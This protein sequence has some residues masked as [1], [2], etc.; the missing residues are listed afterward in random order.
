M[1]TSFQQVTIVGLGLIGGSLGLALRR[2]RLAREVIG[3]SRSQAMVRRAKARRAITWG[4]TDPKRAVQDA[5]L[6]VLAT[7]VDTIVPQGKRL[8][9]WMRPGSVLTDVGSV[10]TDIVAALERSLPRGVAFVGAHPIAGSEQRGLEAAEARL[11]EGAV[12][13]L[14]TTA[15]TNARALRRVK[16]LWASLGSEVKTMSPAQ[17]DRLL[18]GTSHLSHLAAYCLSLSLE[19]GAPRCL[20]QSFLAATRVAKS[21]P[22]LWD[23]ILVSNQ[24]PLRAAMARF[25]RHWRRLHRLLSKADRAALRR[26][27]AQAKARRDALERS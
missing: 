12:C 19:A 14:T 4:T 8:A 20:P 17:H 22:D 26:M 21:D 1:R 27:L 7:P 18:A 25:E 24:V 10:K 13:L 11:F 16:T 2:R 15:R 5:E 23:D 9:R 6:V 3:L